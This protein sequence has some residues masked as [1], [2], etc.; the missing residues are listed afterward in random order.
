MVKFRLL[1]FV[2]HEA[3]TAA[4]EEGQLAGAKQVRQSQHVAI[5]C[6]GAIYVVGV[7]G[8]LP[9]ARKRGIFLRIHEW[10]TSEGD[11]ISIANYIP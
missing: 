10:L 7:N 8:N 3:D 6:R 11:L 2:Q 1:R 9:D 4:I 5:E